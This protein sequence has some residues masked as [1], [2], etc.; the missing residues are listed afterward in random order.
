MV[1]N[2]DWKCIPFEMNNTM[3]MNLIIIK[4]T[5]ITNFLFIYLSK[6]KLKRNI[7]RISQVT[8]QNKFKISKITAKIYKNLQELKSMNQN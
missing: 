7:N 5:V 3:N 1:I 2:H 8:N 4:L 6:A